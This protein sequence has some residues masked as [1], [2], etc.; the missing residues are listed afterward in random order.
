MGYG[1][2]Y[3]YKD[4]VQ[5]FVLMG[6]TKCQVPPPL[7][8]QCSA[9]VLCR[10]VQTTITSATVTFTALLLDVTCVSPT[11]TCNPSHLIYQW[12]SEGG[13]HLVYPFGISR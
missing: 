8:C 1:G 6:S 3:Q 2:M 4:L 10:G 7:G 12:S 11:T 9:S 5:R 13:F